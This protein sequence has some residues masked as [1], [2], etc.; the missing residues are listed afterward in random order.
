MRE[1]DTMLSDLAPILIFD[2]RE[3][4]FPSTIDY[5]LANSEVIYPEGNISEELGIVDIPTIPPRCTIQMRNSDCRFGFNTPSDMSKIPYYIHRI[6]DATNCAWKLSYFV[7]FPSQGPDYLCGCIPW[8]TSTTANLHS[9]ELTVDKDTMKLRRVCLDGEEENF[10]YVELFD[11]HIMVYCNLYSHSLSLTP[12]YSFCDYHNEK[13]HV[14]QPKF[15]DHVDPLIL[16]AL[17]KLVI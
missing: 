14:I 17:T 2:S 5:Y 8:W 16:D 13:G 1:M 12:Q 4:Y 11:G 3:E 9:V 7:F 15:F 6:E 10:K